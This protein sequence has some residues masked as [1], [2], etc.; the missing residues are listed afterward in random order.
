M[1]AEA[2]SENNT[3]VAIKPNND[4]L[5]KLLLD[6][7]TGGVLCVD[8]AQIV[9]LQVHKFRDNVGLCEG[10]IDMQVD[11]SRSLWRKHHLNFNP[12]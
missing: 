11:I 2:L 10:R 1:K 5:T 4:N 9:D 7:L 6:T 12:K 8:N 3:M